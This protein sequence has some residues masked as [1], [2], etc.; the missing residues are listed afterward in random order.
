MSTITTSPVVAAAEQAVIDADK[1]V[2]PQSAEVVAEETAKGKGSKAKAPKVPESSEVA[3]A[4]A[5]P[6]KYS[7]ELK[8]A[9][10]RAEELRGKARTVGPVQV[11]RVQ[12]ALG[13][14]KPEDVVKAF[15][16][17]KDAIAFAGGDKAVTQPDMIKDISSTLADPFCRGR[18]LV[19]IALA[20]AGK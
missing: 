10:K 6:K 2:T 12:N 18:G 14:T 5:T 19:A 8:A 4:A 15:K 16:S 1:G 3:A 13:K 17:Q 20:L 9:A 7:P 11:Q